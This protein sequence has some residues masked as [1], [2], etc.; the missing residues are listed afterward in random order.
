MMPCVRI[1]SASSPNAP[2]SMRVRGW[3]LPARIFDTGK[4]DGGPSGLATALPIFSMAGASAPS[5]ASSPRPNPLGFLVAIVKSSFL[6]FLYLELGS[7]VRVL[8]GQAVPI[9]V[10]VFETVA[11]VQGA[12]G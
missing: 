1:D 7:G 8:G 3:Y 9:R 5:K 6:L 11:A 12:R 4:V 2:S 10:T